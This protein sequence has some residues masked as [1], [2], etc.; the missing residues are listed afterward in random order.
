MDLAVVRTSDGHRLA[1][2]GA[3]TEVANAYL[4]HLHARGYSPG[5]LRGYAFDL[6]NFSRFL[7]ERCIAMVD[8]VPSDLFDYLDWQQRAKPQTSGGRG[9][10][11]VQSVGHVAI[12]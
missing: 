9:S 6:L 10:L 12:W 4:A 8:V 7:D 5:T 2:T 1:G 3:I 11:T